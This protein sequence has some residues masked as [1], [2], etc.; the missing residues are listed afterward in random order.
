MS[1]PSSP[2]AEKIDV[3]YVAHLARIHLRDDEVD[4]L[5]G[6]M[7]HILQYVRELKTLDVAGV[8]PM[9]HAVPVH[10]VFRQDEIKPGLD[11]DKVMANAPA[12]HHGQFIVSRI[13][14]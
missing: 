1:L 3:R 8:E 11:H 9:A 2:S 10:N 5:Q 4:R 7:E 13:I 12:E 14:E 6:Q